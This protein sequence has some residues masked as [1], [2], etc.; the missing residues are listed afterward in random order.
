M[1]LIKKMM[2]GLLVISNVGSSLGSEFGYIYE[3][4]GEDWDSTL[5][6]GSFFPWMSAVETPAPAEP[7]EGIKPVFEDNDHN[8]ASVEKRLKNNIS[9]Y[10]LLIDNNLPDKQILLKLREADLDNLAQAEELLRQI[11]FSYTYLLANKFRL[12]KPKLNT[13]NL[14][15]RAG[16]TLE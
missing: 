13:F 6:W 1:D 14:R 3:G 5:D 10:K 12:K 11:G 2:L 4:D 16:V 8:L 15:G 9:K 7:L